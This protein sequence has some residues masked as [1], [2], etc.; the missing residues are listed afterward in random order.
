VEDG[1]SIAFTGYQDDP[2]KP[3]SGVLFF[4]NS[5]GPKW[6]DHGYG[7]MSYA[8][9]VRYA[10]DAL[11]LELGEPQS[12]KPHVRSEAESLT[13]LGRGR[14]DCE[15]QD[16]KEWGRGMW[17]G[18]TQLMCLAKDGGFVELGFKIDRAGKYR[19]R[20]LATAAPDYGTVRVSFDG[21]AV[22]GTFD[23][24]CGRVSPAG[25]LELGRHQLAAGQHRIRFTVV[26][27]CAASTGYRFGVDAIDLLD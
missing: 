2:K 27:K 7:V 5:F 1:H 20:V 14:C 24:C 26:G 19:V 6:G 16:M 25:S 13:I 21:H 3:G 17:S 9:A 23:L 18:G 4:R 10:N 11:W 12:E 8:Y 15:P 22:E